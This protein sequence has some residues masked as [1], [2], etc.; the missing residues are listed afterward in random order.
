L[1]CP[2]LAG[3]AMYALGIE[4]RIIAEAARAEVAIGTT[5]EAEVSLVTRPVARLAVYLGACVRGRLRRCRLQMSLHNR[6]V[7]LAIVRH[8]VDLTADD[9][10]TRE[11]HALRIAVGRLR[12]DLEAEMPRL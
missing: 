3:A 4:R 11:L 1:P 6:L 7:Q 12:D 2:A 9:R 5:S 10:S 8:R